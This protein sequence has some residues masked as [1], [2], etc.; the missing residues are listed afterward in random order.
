LRSEGLVEEAGRDVWTITHAGQT[1]SSA[2]AARRAL[3]MIAE[4]AL[5]QFLERVQRVNRDT[6][7]LAKVTKVVLLG[8]MLKPE[9][10]RLS[11][12]D[13][14]VELAP[15][16]V[17]VDRARSKIWLAGNTVFPT[18]WSGRCAGIGKSF[19]S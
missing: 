2:T 17:N 8:S 11:D 1:F 12:I 9:V 6:Y 16:E 5:Q 10:K 3:L 13:L 4:K 18:S 14:A 19:D 15:K 7:F